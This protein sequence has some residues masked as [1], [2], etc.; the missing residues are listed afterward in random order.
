MKIEDAKKNA[1]RGIRMSEI[2]VPGPG[3]YS[4]M[5]SQIDKKSDKVGFAMTTREQRISYFKQ[6][7][8]LA[9]NRNNHE[10]RAELGCCHRI[11]N[12]LSK[13]SHNDEL[14]HPFDPEE[15]EVEQP[16]R[17]HSD[18]IFTPNDSLYVRVVQKIQSDAH[19]K[20]ISPFYP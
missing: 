2:K 3:N 15:E 6:A 16:V 13:Q 14:K 12:Y 19:D 5:Y 10:L 4:P 11:L 7:E 18:Y 9:Q 17:G 1:P 20:Q 8:L